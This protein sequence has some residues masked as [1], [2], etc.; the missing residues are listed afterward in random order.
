[1]P[2]LQIFFGVPV[3]PAASAGRFPCAAATSRSPPRVPSRTCSS[4]PSSP[5]SSRSS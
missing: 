4:P 3:I 2:L 1:M 5:S